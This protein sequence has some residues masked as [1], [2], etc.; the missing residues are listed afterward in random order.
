MKENIVKYLACPECNGE[1][2][3]SKP[4]KIDTYDEIKEGTINCQKCRLS[5][6]IKGYIPRFVCEK[7]YSR[8]FGFQWNKHKTSQLDSITGLQISHDR[9][10]NE[11]KWPLNMRGSLILEAGCG[12]GRFTE[13]VLKTGAEVFSFDYST[14]VDA[15]LENNG[16]MNNLHIIQADI[17]NIP[18]K[19][20]YL[21]KSF[22]LV[23]CSTLQMLKRLLKV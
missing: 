18:F 2:Q 17:Y 13:I 1:I 9:F 11:T 4:Y 14:A 22:V 23:Y 3:I 5:W 19:K 10:F 8:S 16:L 21:T 12:A 20:N 6:P 7:N 15:C